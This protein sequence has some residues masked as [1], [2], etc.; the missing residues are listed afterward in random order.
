MIPVYDNPELN[1][2]MQEILTTTPVHADVVNIRYEQLLNNDK[3]NYNLNMDI[4]QRLKLLELMFM[5][6]VTGNPFTISF[7]TIDDVNVTGSWNT[8]LRRIEF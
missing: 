6:D 8:S 1:L 5:T 4:S 7:E 2:D 3:S